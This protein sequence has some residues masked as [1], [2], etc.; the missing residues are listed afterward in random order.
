[1]PLLCQRKLAV[2]LSWEKASALHILSPL[3]AL[4]PMETY[5]ACLYM[6][7]SHN[8][9]YRTISHGIVTFWY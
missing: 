3:D 5:S 8:A 7:A 2:T 1:M 6:S 9:R 4:H